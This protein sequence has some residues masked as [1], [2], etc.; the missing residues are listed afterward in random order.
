VAQWTRVATNQ[1]D[2]SGN[3]SLSK[4]VDPS[5]PQTYYQIQL[6]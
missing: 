2:S 1:F 3:F 6:Q 5:A 4:P